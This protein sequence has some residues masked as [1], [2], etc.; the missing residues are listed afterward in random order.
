[1]EAERYAVSRVVSKTNTKKYRDLTSFLCN[2]FRMVFFSS[3]TLDALQHYWISRWFRKGL[4]FFYLP[5]FCCL[6]RVLSRPLL[7]CVFAK[8]L[9]HKFSN[10]NILQMCF[11]FASECLPLQGRENYFTK[12]VG[13]WCICGSSD[14]V[15]CTDLFFEWSHDMPGHVCYQ[16]IKLAN[17]IKS[18]WPFC[19]YLEMLSHQIYWWWMQKIILGSVLKVCVGLHLNRMKVHLCPWKYW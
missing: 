6:E 1:M 2:F 3:V 18:G 7:V 8:L 4:S 12:N 16:G 17:E 13:M 9:W 11:L 14:N 5:R 10:Y 15:R 19:S